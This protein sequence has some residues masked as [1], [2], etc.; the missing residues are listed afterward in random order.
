MPLLRLPALVLVALAGTALAACGDAPSPGTDAALPVRARMDSADAV[1]AE[2]ERTLWSQ[3]TPDRV[4]EPVWPLLRQVY[5]RRRY[6]P[7]WVGDTARLTAAI[8]ALCS[9]DVLGLDPAAYLPPALADAATA[10]AARADL[11]LDLSAAL[12]ALGRDLAVGRAHPESLPSAWAADSVARETTLTALLAAPDPAAALAQLAPTYAEYRALSEATGRYRSMVAAGG[13]AEVPA[14]P[15]LRL[16]RRD[17][18]VALLRARL[19]ATGDAGSS[20]AAADRFDR[21]LS[22]ALAG[23]QR[24]HGLAASGVLDSATTAALNVPARAR[25]GQLEANLERL[26]WLPRQAPAMYLLADLRSGRF[27]AYAAGAPA[28]ATGLTGTAALADSAPPVA[29]HALSAVVLR[30]GRIELPLD[31]SAAVFYGAADSAARRTAA[32]PFRPAI[33]VANA[34]ALARFLLRSM[35]EWNDEGVRLAARK[36]SATAV[37]L[38]RTAAVYVLSPT[39][40]VDDG[41]VNFRRDRRGRDSTLAAMIA[42]PRA[43]SPAACRT[44]QAEPAE[45]R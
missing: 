23:F 11:D 6:A 18:R 34:G 38:P 37:A 1:N 29:R 19:V 44:G 32:P 36:D 33:R 20:A 27:W 21:G 26:R 39:A 8:D 16:G 7:L 42:P 12:A 4:A 15:T 13:W 28:V 2:L 41:I 31:D 30:A 45:T 17:P 22:A 3:R 14:G 40:F 10:P 25:L 24:R 43:G 9:A 5:E 35:P